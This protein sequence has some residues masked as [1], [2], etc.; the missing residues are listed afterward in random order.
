M[1]LHGTRLEAAELAG[2]QLVG[3]HLDSSNL[4]QA[5]L[6]GAN[7][8]EANLVGVPMRNA[9][10]S[11]TD[12]SKADLT[13]A[14]LKK[15]VLFGSDLREAVLLEAH[16]EGA[17]LATAHLES[18]DLEAAHL[19]GASLTDAHLEGANLTGAY[20]EN[21]EWT[22][23]RI[24]NKTQLSP[25]YFSPDH[26]S[27]NDGSESIVLE[28]RDRKL[29][30]GTIRRLGSLPLFGVSYAALSISLLTITGIGFLNQTRVVEWFEYPIPLPGRILWLL[31]SSSAL[32][33]GSTLYKVMC[34]ERVQAFSES[35]WVEAHGR[36][37][38]LYIAEKIKRPWQWPTNTF[39]WLGALTGGVLLLERVTVALIYIVRD[40]LGRV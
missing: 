6:K 11:E 39:L 4:S 29:S 15:A 26:F 30:W 34:P 22:Q 38:L 20:V 2:A 27:L 31:L 23:T 16:L 1:Y 5:H 14:D 18:A 32:A 25:L 9:D 17:E 8:R 3:A 40:L 35:E 7:L 10:L 19:E 13:R 12:L 28:D 24:S 37:R 33:I 21:T 36:P